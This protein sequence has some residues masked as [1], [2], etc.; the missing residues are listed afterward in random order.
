MSHG[1]KSQNSGI[2]NN[3]HVIPQSN[4]SSAVPGWKNF[5]N[6]IM[7]NLSGQSGEKMELIPHLDPNHPEMS[8]T[9]FYGNRQGLMTSSS[10]TR[11]TAMGKNLN[12]LCNQKESLQ[13]LRR[14]FYN[15]SNVNTKNRMNGILNQQPNTTAAGGLP[16]P[17][18]GPLIGGLVGPPPLNSNEQNRGIVRGLGGLVI[19]RRKSMVGCVGQQRMPIE[20]KKPN[21]SDIKKKE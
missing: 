15:N 12:Q 4:K 16:H 19:E 17:T 6:N 2:Q 5:E 9:R 7:I 8:H 11:P 14:T 18:G 1:A 3:K 10:N 21:I 13:S 20:I